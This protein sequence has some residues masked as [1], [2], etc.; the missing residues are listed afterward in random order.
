MDSCDRYQAQML[1]YLYGL[2]EEDELRAFEEHLESCSTCP[3]LLRE[4]REQQRLLAAAARLTFPGVRFEVPA[5]TASTGPRLLSI[6]KEPVR[7]RWL[8]WAVAV[9]FTR[10][11]LGMH[12]ISDV[13]AGIVAGGLWVTVTTLAYE[14]TRRV[15]SATPPRARSPPS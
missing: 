15:G 5:D 7:T 1:E 11:Y 12:W 8:P 2:P 14:T 9:G 13:A 10:V 3:V 4:A 6:S